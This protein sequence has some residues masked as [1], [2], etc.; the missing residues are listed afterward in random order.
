MH[1]W[2]L[3]KRWLI[4]KKPIELYFPD[5]IENIFSLCYG[6]HNLLLDSG[7]FDDWGSNGL[8]DNEDISIEYDSLDQSDVYYD[9]T[10]FATIF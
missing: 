5:D 6:F 7:G 2:D 4:L 1:I 3:K 9:T 10:S 8:L